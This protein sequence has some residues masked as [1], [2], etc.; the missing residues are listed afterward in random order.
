MKGF[1]KKTLAG[2]SLAGMALAFAGCYSTP[3]LQS[4]YQR[5]VDP[6]YPQRYGAMARASIN[7]TFG[8]QIANGHALEQTVWNYYFEPGTSILTPGGMFRLDYLTRR[9]PAPDPHIFLQTAYDVPF[10][11]TRPDLFV[12]GRA[13]LN[14]RRIQTIY[15]YLQ[16]QTA[17]RPVPFKV[18]V[19]DPS[20]VGM[21]AASMLQS[22]QQR[23]ASFKGVMPVQATQSTG[24]GR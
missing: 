2:F 20:P 1:I 21:A 11:A 22:I 10:D 7:E 3:S 15:R 8:A 13:D 18:T 4:R 6:C 9:R 17:E 19:H 24:I 16:A 23:D 14:N 5:F 12:K